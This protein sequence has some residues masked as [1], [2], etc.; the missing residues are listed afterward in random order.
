VIRAMENR[1]RLRVL[2]NFRARICHYSRLMC[3]RR[4]DAEE[5]AQGTLLNVFENFD[6][7]PEPERIRPWVFR[8]AKNAC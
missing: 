1:R 4:E 6:R 2:W 7:L 5:V 3:G 8:V